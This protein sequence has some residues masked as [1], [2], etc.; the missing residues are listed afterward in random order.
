MSII[1]I[2]WGCA[3]DLKLPYSERL[4]ALWGTSPSRRSSLNPS[5]LLLLELAPRAA[6]AS[7]LARPLDQRVQSRGWQHRGPSAERQRHDRRDEGRPRFR[8]GSRPC[9]V[10]HLA[11]RPQR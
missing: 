1:S 11:A 9:S 10:L 3:F 8:T 2:P 6:T 5:S 4:T 7:L